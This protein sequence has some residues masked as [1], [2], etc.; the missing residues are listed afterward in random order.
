SIGVVRGQRLT[1]LGTEIDQFLGIPYAEPPVGALRFAKPQ[2][3]VKPFED[4]IDGTKPKNSCFQNTLIPIANLTESEDC[5]VLSIWG[6]SRGNG[7][8]STSALKPVMFW[9]YGGS[10][11]T[12]SIFFP[13]VDGTVLSTRDIVFVSVNYRV[14]P[15][16]WLYGGSESPAPGNQ[17]LY[18]QLLA[19]QWVR[20]NIHR[21]G[22]D[23][24][25]ITIFGESAGSWS[26]S[27]HVLSPL[28][29]GLFQRAI[30]ESGAVFGNKEVPD[31]T[32]DVALSQAKQMAKAF[33]CSDDSQWLDCLRHVD[34]KQLTKYMA[35]KTNPIVGSQFLPLNAQNSFQTHNYS[36]GIDIL[37]GVVRDEGSLLARMAYPKCKSLSSAA[38]FTDLVKSVTI[39]RLDAQ[40]ITDFY[41]RGVNTSA[42]HELESAFWQ[43]YGDV[44]IVCPTYLFA[45]QFAKWSPKKRVYFYDWTYVSHILAPMIGCTEEMGV[46]HASELEYVFGAPIVMNTTDRQF[47]DNVVTMW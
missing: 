32:P 31:L 45:K 33:N 4:V 2:P 39:P 38:D 27:A 11:K 44:H 43:F 47:S 16:G 9:I 12:G 37:A 15:F 29:R 42:P 7:S 25:R 30:L 26:V 1:V 22:G 6:P 5:L 36:T 14:G 35:L 20:Q 46:C 34:A 13:I 24:N 3:I 17:G 40:K 8:S 41:T 21:F 10:F 23:P 18:D 28:S 19:L